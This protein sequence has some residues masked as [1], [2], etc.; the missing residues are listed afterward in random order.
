MPYFIFS[1]YH[2]DG[3]IAVVFHLIQLML[4]P[5]RTPSKL[6]DVSKRKKKF[7][8]TNEAREAFIVV[9]ATETLYKEHFEAK[10]KKESV[11]PY[12]SI[13]G[14]LSNPEKII[15]GF[16]NIKYEFN[17]ITRAIDICFKVY[18]TFNFAYPNAC[19]SMWQFINAH[20]YGL[21]DADETVNPA[22]LLLVSNIK[23]IIC[24][25]FIFCF[26]Y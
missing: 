21:D 12:I 26:E 22:T 6:T 19:L 23:S 18:H 4:P 20:F 15:G 25:L 14:S 7:F 16:E 13:I 11:P 10:I 8:S 24:R 9:Y 2:I 3:K 17:S 5:S 1:F